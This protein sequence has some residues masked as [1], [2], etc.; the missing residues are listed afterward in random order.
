MSSMKIEGEP[1]KR[2]R[3]Y[4][5]D[6][7]GNSVGEPLAEYDSETEVLA[8]KRRRDWHYMI[9]ENRKPITTAELTT[10][11]W[12][13]PICEQTVIKRPDTAPILPSGYFENCKLRDHMVGDECIARRDPET[14]KRLA[15]SPHS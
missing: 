11:A 5:A 3:I 2:F 6:L 13:C 7:Q 4:R 8:Y 9:R 15:A 10:R 14:A 1:V 12:K